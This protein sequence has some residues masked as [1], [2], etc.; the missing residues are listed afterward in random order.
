MFGGVVICSLLI[1]FTRVPDC[2]GD[3]GLSRCRCTVLTPEELADLAETHHEENEKH[4]ECT[5]RG[6]SF[7]AIPKKPLCEGFVSFL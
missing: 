5:C 2:T 7:S 4:F 6:E 3:G 1:L